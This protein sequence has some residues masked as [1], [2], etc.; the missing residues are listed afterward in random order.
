VNDD[1]HMAHALGLGARGLGRTWPN[2]SVGCIIVAGGRVVTLEPCAHH[3]KSPPC[4][5][6]LI[7]AG[8]ARVV[9]ALTDPDPRVAGRG[10]SGLRAAGIAV[11]EG[12][13]TAEATRANA[14]FLKRV[15]EGLP[16]VTLKL[17]TSLDGH[18]AT[19][20]GESRWITGSR[21]GQAPPAP[22]TPT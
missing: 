18:T 21:S 13:M 6:A 4:C 11:T 17:A 2:P 16:L 12:V 15:T 1:N 19:A 22:I 3:G 14:G 8:I 10:H 5:D 9:T 20:T 7:A